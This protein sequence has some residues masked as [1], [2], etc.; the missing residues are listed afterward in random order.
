M[1]I[2]EYEKALK[3]GEKSYHSSTAKGEY[4][5]LP[6]LDQFLKNDEIQ[7]EIPLGLM[8]IP[9]DQIVGTKTVG[10]QTAFAPNFMPL[11]APKTEFAMKW[12]SLIDYQM[13]SGVTDPIVCYEYLNRYYVLEGNKRVSV[14][15]FL[16]AYSIE[17]NVTRIVPKFSSDPAVRI[18][19]E[20]MDFYRL[21]GINYIWFSKE[22]SY[23]KLLAAC[24]KKTNEVWT[25]DEKM[26]FSSNYMR[27]LKVFEEKGGKKLRGTTGDAML[28]YLSVY[29][30][31]QMSDKTENEL[32]Q[33]LSKLWSEFTVLE[34]PAEETL[35]LD[36]T[37]SGDAGLISR[38]LG[39]SGPKNL[40]VAFVHDRDASQSGWTYSHELGRAHL[41]EVFGS[42]I[43]TFSISADETMPEL[44]DV[45][46]KAVEDGAQI[47]FATSERFLPY[48]LKAA[49]AHPE[50]KFLNCGINRPYKSIRTYYGRIYEAKFLE[51]MIA[52]AYAENNRI[53]Y[54]ADYPIY[55][56]PAA[57]NA[58]ARGAQMT[59]PRAQIY[60]HWNG[61]KDS[62]LY[63]LV[64]SNQIGVV[65]NIDMMRPGIK[66]RRYGLYC[67]RN[68]E[69]AG[70]LAMPVWNWGKFYEKIV[71]DI[72]SG[73]WNNAETKAHPALS[74]WWGISGDII[75]LITSR[76]LPEGLNTLVQIVRSEICSGKFHPFGGVIRKQDH[77]V[78]GDPYSVLSPEEIIT[79]DWLNE[80]VIGSIPK[81][82]ELTDFAKE[83]ISVQGLEPTP[84]KSTDDEDTGISG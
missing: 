36:K 9:L 11:M 2:I 1:S 59:N 49:V 62:D 44:P 12:A 72:L 52:G 47:V 18:F 68:G 13:S 81:T 54:C 26:D 70:S 55:G 48:A 66:N 5:Y 41:E 24:D 37:E 7:T 76:S 10:R 61:V 30:Y 31:A 17:G 27:F 56:T 71:R 58:F 20:Y 29:P 57:I 22:G 51:G 67:I 34:T 80:N 77:T 60:L 53:A 33:E 32:R 64:I 21:T 82:E 8:D 79:M 4:P 63:D 73:S 78:C 45:L 28:L 23:A 40:T 75:D 14:F 42:K 69:Y 6:A 83:I 15:K 25:E 16:N 65:A 46:E 74:Y 35:V 38:F 50:V 3:L 39:T 84:I 43:R 19:Y